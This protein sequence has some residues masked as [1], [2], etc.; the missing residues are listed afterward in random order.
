MKQISKVF[1]ITHLDLYKEPKLKNAVFNVQ[2]SQKL[3]PRVIPTLRTLEKIDNIRTNSIFNAL[4]LTILNIFNSEKF[5]LK[6]IFVMQHIVLILKKFLF[7]VG[8]D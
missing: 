6:T 8:L 3:A 7:H 2:P 4:I 5:F 1:E